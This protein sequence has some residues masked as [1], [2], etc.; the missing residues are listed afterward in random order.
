MRKLTI[1]L[2]VAALTLGLAA[3]AAAY[4]VKIGATIYTNVFYAFQTGNAAGRGNVRMPDTT[5]F[6]AEASGDSFFWISWTSNDKT[7]GA[8]IELWLQGGPAHGATAVG[9]DY[10]YGWYKFGRCTLTLGHTDNLFASA[11]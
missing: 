11:P 9:L 10:M 3:S 1:W 2:M 6:V 5:S 7:T 4:Q 8:Y